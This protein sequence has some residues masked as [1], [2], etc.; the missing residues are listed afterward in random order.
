MTVTDVQV[1]IMMR[2]RKKGRTQEQAAASANV[3]SIADLPNPVV[4]ETRMC[5]TSGAESRASNG[6]PSSV[7]PNIA[8]ASGIGIASGSRLRNVSGRGLGLENSRVTPPTPR[9]RRTWGTHKPNV[10]D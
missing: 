8:V 3:R 9:L 6:A 5:A 10:K 1:R 7:R 4:P 2:E